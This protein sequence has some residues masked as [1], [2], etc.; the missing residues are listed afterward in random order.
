MCAAM[1][2][3]PCHTLVELVAEHAH[4]L[5]AAESAVKVAA[6]CAAGSAALR[7]ALVQAGIVTAVL[8]AC[9]EA[10]ACSTA[11]AGLADVGAHECH[12]AIALLTAWHSHASAHLYVP[13]CAHCAI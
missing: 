7:D 8:T 5:A 4:D 3:A 13:Y 6:V 1:G 10:A 2:A 9:R 12:D 11:D